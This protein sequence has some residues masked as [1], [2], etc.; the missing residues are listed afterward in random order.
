MNWQSNIKTRYFIKYFIWNCNSFYFISFISGLMKGIRTNGSPYELCFKVS[1]LFDNK[2]HDTIWLWIWQNSV[3]DHETKIYVFFLC[4]ENSYNYVRIYWVI[5][6][7]TKSSQ[8]SIIIISRIFMNC[9]SGQNHNIYF[10]Y[11]QCID[12]LSTW[13]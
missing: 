6:T 10:D 11:I 3:C 7:E 12:L 8:I 5:K 13:R 2:F 4:L 9:D 1:T